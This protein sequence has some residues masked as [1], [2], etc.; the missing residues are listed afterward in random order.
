MTGTPEL[1]PTCWG[2]H[3]HLLLDVSLLTG[4]GIPGAEGEVPPED[5]F[6]FNDYAQKVAKGWLQESRGGKVNTYPDEARGGERRRE[7]S[8]TL[9][10]DVPL[11]G[12]GILNGLC[13]L[14]TIKSHEITIISENAE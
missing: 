11:L 9:G 8:D 6:P 12:T 14:K 1:G 5:K 7:V 2:D 4:P 3:S 10:W 13:L